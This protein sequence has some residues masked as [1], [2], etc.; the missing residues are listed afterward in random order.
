MSAESTIRSYVDAFNRAD[1]DALAS[2]YAAKTTYVQ[3]FAPQPLTSPDEVRGFESAMFAGFSDVRVDI[4]WLV[5]GGDA[6]AA[7][8][9]ISAKHTADMPL[10][11]GSVLA[12]TGRTITLQTAEHMRVDEGG[13]IVEHQR[14]NDTAAFLRQLTE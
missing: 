6:V 5:A 7:G 13:K 14:Y 9:R 8:A 11:D 3:P 1:V 2:H 12:A 10:P 4:E